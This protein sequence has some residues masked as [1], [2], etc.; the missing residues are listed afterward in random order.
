MKP[1]R[2]AS[3]VT[4]PGRVRLTADPLPELVQKMCELAASP[5]SLAVWLL[6]KHAEFGQLVNLSC[7]ATDYEP[8]YHRNSFAMDYACVNLLSKFQDFELGVDRT[9]VAFQKWEASEVRCSQVNQ[10]FRNRWVG[11]GSPFPHSVEE[12]LHLARQ[13][14]RSVLGPV[15]YDY[16]RSH[17]KFG[18][19]A[20]L[21]TRRDNTAAYHKFANNG[22]CT[23][24]ILP[25][26]DDIFSNEESD[27]RGE[28]PHAA[29]LVDAS[30]LSFVPKNAKTDR[31][32]CVEPRWNSYLQSGVGRLLEKR[33]KKLG[34]NLEDQTANQKAAQRAFVDGL[35]TIDLSSASDS[36]STNFVIDMFDGEEEW[37]DLLLKTRCVYTSYKGRKIRLEKISSMG[38]GYTFPL[39]TLLFYC[40]SHAAMSVS[41]QAH[42]A[43]SD[44][45]VYGDDI[46]LPKESAPL[47]IEALGHFGFSTNVD[48]TFVTGN[49][50]ESCG[51]DYF[52]GIDVRPFFVTKKVVT[53]SDGFI[54]CN[55][56]AAFARSCAGDSGF[57]SREVWNLRESVVRRIPKSLRLF[58]PPEAGDG[59]IHSTFD[60]TRP[61]ISRDPPRRKG[62]STWEGFW[63]KAMVVVPVRKY[64]FNFYGH[65]YSKLSADLD[66]GQSFTTRNDVRRKV[67][68]VYVPTYTDV[69]LV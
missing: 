41:G 32:I 48:K 53:V 40:V 29:R 51:K 50:Y 56:L 6:F 57:A 21:D 25:L 66:T 69:L 13:K 67:D 19:G 47:L 52:Q 30:R 26:Y 22:A 17:C 20:D 54:L 58:G 44:L 9:A 10:I 16:I 60:V 31:A 23:P 36:M 63:L 4:D 33:M 62:N 42:K 59:V 7:K 8:R 1:Q 61:R 15:D 45:R 46:I 65:L 27:Y 12:V 24:G 34:I 3:T 2:V 5:R 55:Q 49:F 14:L 43:Y 11:Q 39:E 28:Y 18:P 64:G 38:N 68:W 35:A 37:L